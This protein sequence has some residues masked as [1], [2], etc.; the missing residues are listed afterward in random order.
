MG[1]TELDMLNTDRGLPMGMLEHLYQ[2]TAEQ[3]LNEEL[4]K[5]CQ[6]G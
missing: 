4:A 3:V 1:E 5:T 2:S 6:F